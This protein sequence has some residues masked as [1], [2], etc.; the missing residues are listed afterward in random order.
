MRPASLCAICLLL[1]LYGTVA[2][3][4]LPVEY[5]GKDDP[6]AAFKMRVL[7]LGNRVDFNLRAQ[8]PGDGIDYRMVW[9]PCP[10]LKPQFAF[11][12][13]EQRP[14]RA[15]NSLAPR[16]QFPTGNSGKSRPAE[17][18]FR[19]HPSPFDKYLQ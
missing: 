14:L 18:S 3:Q 9:N 10:S 13:H 11:A 7:L 2:A 1:F 17:F 19:Q 6:C 8:K 16:F 12:L 5:I 4:Q 15:G